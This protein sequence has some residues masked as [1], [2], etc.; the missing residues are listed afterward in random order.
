MKSHN[1]V[2]LLVCAAAFGLLA[3]LPRAHAGFGNMSVTSTQTTVTAGEAASYMRAGSDWNKNDAT[4]VVGGIAVPKLAQFSKITS[5]RDGTALHFKFQIPDITSRRDDDTVLICGDQIIVQIGQ[6]GSSATALAAGSDF[7][8]QITLLNENQATLQ[9]YLPQ[10]VGS[11]LVGNWKNVAEATTTATVS[12]TGAAPNYVVQLDIPIGEV[13]VT[14]A[15]MNDPQ[16]AIGLAIALL[17]DL[18]HSHT[19]GGSPVHEATGTT[20]PIGMGLLPASD[21]VFTCGIAGAPTPETATGNWKNPS[22]W[23]R[24]YFNLASP[25]GD[26]TLDQ[27][28]QYTL[29][30][31]IRIGRCNVLNF[32][33][34]PEV[35]VANWESI[36]QN[37]AN[38][39]YLFNSALPCRMAIWIDAKVAGSGVVNK[40]FI[41][42]WG[43]PG[44]GQKDWFFVGLTDPVPVSAPNTPVTLI[45]NAPPPQNFT[46]HPCLR[47]YVVPENLTQAQIDQIKAIDT[48]AK[49][50]A[51]VN[52]IVLP[53]GA[54]KSAQM[55]FS[56]LAGGNCALGSCMPLAATFPENDEIDWAQFGFISSAHAQEPDDRRPDAG[57]GRDPDGQPGDDRKSNLVRVIAYGFGVAQPESGRTYSYVESIGQV[58]Y[59]IPS[60][61]FAQGPLPVVFDVVNPA[62]TES[63]YANGSAIEIASPPRRIFVHV[64]TDVVSGDPVP[65]IDTS[66]LD[67]IAEGTLEPGQVVPVEV[68]IASEPSQPPPPPWWK[69]YWWVLLILIIFLLLLLFRRRQPA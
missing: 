60:S 20:F 8:Y 15:Q 37:V 34:I 36:Q 6:P 52:T 67:R 4:A 38:N 55:N 18:G 39:W 19:V 28:P 16:G 46:G 26:V 64:T 13:G 5:W 48:D 25:A 53:Q 33:Q 43:R 47:V 62:L 56:N 31:A 3:V 41:A 11:P 1:P 40:R 35:T 32:G 12:V 14:A 17:N 24:G 65:T 69:K 2:S 23:G 30:R 66:A 9:R 49:L 21:P 10:P 27:G 29:S 58:G 57:A 68:S 54:A 42:V 44:I 7:R 61:M 45:W 51:V 22:T 59:A 63:S 50:D